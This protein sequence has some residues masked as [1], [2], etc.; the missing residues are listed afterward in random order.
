MNTLRETYFKIYAF[1]KWNFQ[2]KASGR[3]DDMHFEFTYRPWTGNNSEETYYLNGGGWSIV[4]CP[5]VIEMSEML[6]VYGC[7]LYK[8][9]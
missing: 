9:S 3:R 5:P 7:S 8:V 4:R 2:W 1:I 6:L